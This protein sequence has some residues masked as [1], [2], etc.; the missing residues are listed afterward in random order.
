MPRGLKI[1]LA[2]SLLANLG[3]AFVYFRPRDTPAVD[4]SRAANPPAPTSTLAADWQALTAATENDDQAYVAR[5]RAEGFPS[6]ILRAFVKA[7][8]S[9]RFAEQRRTARKA[10]G[11]DD[12]WRPYSV[13]FRFNPEAE[14]AQ[15]YI[16]RQQEE[17]LRQLIGSDAR[18][19]LETARLVRQ[20]GELPP[21]KIHQLER[22][23]RDYADLNQQIRQSAGGTRLKN[24]YDELDY[25]AKECDADIAAL[26]TPEE[27]TAYQLRSSRTAFN[28]QWKIRHFDPSEQEYVALYDLHK[29]CDERSKT[30]SADEKKKAEQQLKQDIEATLGPERFAE[31]KITTDPSY[32]TILKIA[33]EFGLPASNAKEVVA[34]KLDAIQRCIAIKENP[35]FTQADRDQQIAALVAETKAALAHKLGSN[36]YAEDLKNQYISSWIS[37][38]AESTGPSKP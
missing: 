31:Y 37:N 14:A 16:D 19:P 32:D 36:D 6:H 22:V 17:L 28:L 23:L 3:L 15:R 5:L 34:Y 26:L 24:D 38:V 29:N 2:L 35:A 10:T 30:A 11:V 13:R 27:L 25:I 20:F 8:L 9:V 1:I 4:F 21:D 7:E 18:S 12:Y 33:N